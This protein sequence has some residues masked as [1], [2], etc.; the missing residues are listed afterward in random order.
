MLCFAKVTKIISVDRIKFMQADSTHL[1]F[2][3]II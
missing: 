2:T 3:S 1:S